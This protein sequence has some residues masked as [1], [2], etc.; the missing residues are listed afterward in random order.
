MA[1]AS[2]PGSASASAPQIASFGPLGQPARAVA[3]LVANIRTGRGNAAR[4][5]CPNGAT[6]VGRCL[7]SE[8]LLSFSIGAGAVAT[9]W[10]G[11]VEGFRQHVGEDS[12]LGLVCWDEVGARTATTTLHDVLDAIVLLDQ[13]DGLASDDSRGPR[14][15]CHVASRRNSA[16][17]RAIMRKLSATAR[18]GRPLIAHWYD[19][20]PGFAAPER[21]RL[22]RQADLAWQRTAAFL[23]RHLDR[24]AAGRA[25]TI[26]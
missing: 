18:T 4:I 13:V 26:G 3:A 15:L 6:T 1:L 11:A 10:M 25:S 12:P 7:R 23:V 17:R 22:D 16:E 20:V 19:A 5:A 14:V 21:D 2:Q 24:S 8:G 9:D